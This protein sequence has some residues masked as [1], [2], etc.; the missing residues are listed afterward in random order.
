MKKIRII[1]ARGVPATHGGF[2][3]FAEQ[4][5][6]HLVSKGW[7]VVVYCQEEGNEPP[8]RD[9]WRGVERIHI[10]VRQRGPLGT[11]VFDWLTI[12]DV[13]RYKDLCV[14]CGYNTAVFCARLRLHGIQ[15]IISMD[16]IDWLRSKWGI[17]AKTWLWLNERAACWL[18]NHL[19]A[20]HPEIKKHLSTRV[21]PEKITTIV[22]GAEPVGQVSETPLEQ[23]GLN[24]RNYFTLIARPEP[25]NSI[26]E[27]VQGFSKKP[28]GMKLLVLGNYNRNDAFQRK[29]LDIAS[30]EVIFAGAIYDKD[31]V[32]SLR[33]HCT[34]YFHGHQVGGTNPSLVEAMAA[35]NAVIAHDNRFNRW[36]LGES[37]CY[38]SDAESLS[39]ALEYILSKQDVLETMRAKS[40]QRYKEEFTWPHILKQCEELLI[41]FTENVVQ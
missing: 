25:E 4:L 41:P 37:G 9:E 27:I 2:E 3:V 32:Q 35:S 39:C 29:V 11:I 14:T 17:A 18:G 1:G 28:R 38:F 33:S 34:A 10:P 13:V 12:R 30:D 21:Y 8:W 5:S 36:V 23:W 20:D 19:I 26:L 40:Y 24:S 16:G 31:V 22:Q 6:L 7:Q 15:N